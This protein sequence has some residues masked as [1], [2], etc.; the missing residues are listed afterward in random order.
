MP[1]LAVPD[2]GEEAAGAVRLAA[3]VWKD[4]VPSISMGKEADAW[5]SA[6][7]ETPCH[8]VAI[9]PG[10]ARRRVKDIYPAGFELNFP[11]GASFLLTSESSLGDLNGR[12]P[13]PV[14]MD[15]FRP[16]V[17][18]RGAA[19]YAEDGWRTLRIGSVAFPA[20]Y[21]C[22]RCVITTMDQETGART[23]EPLATLAQYRK[24]GQG[25]VFG[26]RLI[27]A[28]SGTIRIG[29]EVVV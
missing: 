5:F 7:L 16:N 15:R 23:A 1:A 24:Q 26:Q 18:V 11:D 27:H 12:L 19:P 29:D 4:E 25:I 17:V 9:A 22:E 3:R 21:G 2:P 28:G 13:A 10:A 8:L 6:A 14:P 20:A